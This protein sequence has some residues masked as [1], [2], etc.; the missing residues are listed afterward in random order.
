MGFI[1]EFGR[2]KWASNDV[3]VFDGERRYL[4]IN[5]NQD[6][7]LFDKFSVQ[8]RLWEEGSKGFLLRVLLGCRPTDVYLTLDELKCIRNAIDDMVAFA[9]E[10]T[11]DITDCNSP[12]ASDGKYSTMFVSKDSTPEE[13]MQ[14][15][16]GKEDGHEV[17]KNTR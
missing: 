17:S 4:R 8:I 1:K 11:L 3:K 13:F 9:E 10:K 16:Q 14:K 15:V 5:M 7:T 12:Q 2:I 6:S